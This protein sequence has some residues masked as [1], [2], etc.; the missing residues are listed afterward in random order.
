MKV[1]KV[2]HTS[3]W[4]A[5]AFAVIGLVWGMISSSQ[6][7]LFDG[8]YS[9]IGVLLA[10]LSLLSLRYLKKEDQAHFPYGKESIEPLVVIIKSVIISVLCLLAIISS[11]SEIAAGG[12]E[13]VL[14]HALGYA[15]FSTAG[16]YA[17]FRLMKT[18]SQSELIK[19]EAAQWLMDTWLSAV[20]LIGFFIAWVLGQTPLTFLVPYI[21]PFMVLIVSGYFLTVPYSLIKTNGR[22]LLR[23]T[24]SKDIR[25]K[26]ASAVQAVKS[27]YRMEEAVLRTSKIGKTLYVEIDVVVSERSLVYTVEEMDQVR[28]ELEEKLAGIPLEKWITVSFT[29][30]VKWT[31]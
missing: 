3:V 17:V 2:L 18:N 22:E 13:V 8:A 20:V 29:K 30:D 4:G 16:C 26:I 7:I 6:M 1:S 31:V 14:S 11:V 27:S 24:P 15:A 25:E 21:D 28:E 10:L 23:M 12:R 19:A 5:L 9:M